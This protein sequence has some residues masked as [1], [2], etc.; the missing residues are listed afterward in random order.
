MV[1]S[2]ARPEPLTRIGRYTKIGGSFGIL[3]PLDIRRA[4][5]MVLGDFGAMTY[6]GPELVIVR[7]TAEMVL[8]R[9]RMNAL[10]ERELGRREARDDKTRT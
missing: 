1:R 6:Y 10:F 3:L 7:L 5:N 9:T 4:M 2:I 8:D